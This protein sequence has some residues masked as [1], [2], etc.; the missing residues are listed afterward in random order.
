MYSM[1]AVVGRTTIYFQVA[2]KHL[3]EDIS[4]KFRKVDEEQGI[5]LTNTDL[6]IIIHDFYGT[7]FDETPVHI[8][9]NEDSVTFT[10]SDY[11]MITSLDYSQ[12]E[13]HVHNGIS[14]KHA[15]INLYSSWLIQHDQ[16]LLIHSSCIMEGGKGWLFAGPSGAGKS[17][18]AEL[19]S[20][21]PLLSDEATILYVEDDGIT[22]FDSPFRSELEDRCQYHSC[23][24]GGIHLLVQ[25]LEVSRVPLSKG[26]ALIQLLDKV[27]YWNH[28]HFETAKMIKLCKQVVQQVPAYELYFQK[29]DSF[30]ERIS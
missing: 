10:R 12:A 22:V 20:P 29:N 17:T 26:D 3:Y 21:R 6:R 24:L 7:V 25:S 30:W 4:S 1:L 11:K 15:L 2:T 19:S 13:I 9:S 23:P 18:V 27:F 28:S 16:G 8:Q 5:N 14:L